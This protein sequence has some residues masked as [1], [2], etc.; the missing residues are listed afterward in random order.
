MK[1][2]QALMKWWF[3][4]CMVMAMISA[5]ADECVVLLHGL[6]RT[7]SS[8]AKMEKSLRQAGYQVVNIS[9]PS[10][11]HTIAELSERAITRGL[12]KCPDG[13]AINFVTHSLGGILVRNYLHDREIKNL[14]RVVMLGPPNAGSQV[15]DRLQYVPGFKAVNGPAGV[16]LSTAED[17]VPNKLGPVDFDLGVIAGTRTVNPILSTMLPN[18]DDGKV[19]V[20]NTK[21][22]GMNDHIQLPVTHTFM[23]R[24]KK[25]VEQVI[26]Y[27]KQGKFKHEKSPG[28]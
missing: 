27:L 2:Q 17:S 7:D 14:H 4:V 8:M 18:P 6:A 12:A 21:I 24:N 10:T 9:Y 20:E 23:M 26:H 19:S 25:V 1:R 16:E 3:G 15:V 11:R 5:E 22:E 13:V 28:Q